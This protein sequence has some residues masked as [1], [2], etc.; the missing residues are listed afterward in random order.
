MRVRIRLFASLA[1]RAGGRELSV[2]LPEGITAGE[3]WEALCRECPT[4]RGAP[5]PLV[6]V[7][8]EYAPSDRALDGS[9][10]IALLPPVSGG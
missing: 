4:L 2:E 8:L 10:E 9:E 1:D 3:L 7:N 6:A 5:R